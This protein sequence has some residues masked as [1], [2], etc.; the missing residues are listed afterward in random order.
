MATRVASRS[1]IWRCKSGVPATTSNSTTR[2]SGG[3]VSCEATQGNLPPE[4]EDGPL[5]VVGELDPEIAQVGRGAVLDGHDDP[6]VA[7][8]S[9]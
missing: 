9:G 2:C 3:S 1:Q 5:T 6:L 4:P 8:V 7:A